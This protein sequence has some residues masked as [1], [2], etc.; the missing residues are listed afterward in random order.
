MA[1]NE[2]MGIATTAKI[3]KHPVHPMLIAFPIAFFLATLAG[4]LT[5]WLS[6]DRLA[7]DIAFWSLGAGILTAALAAVAGLIDFAGNARIRALSHAWQHMIGNVIVV[8]LAVISFWIRYRYGAADAILPWGLTLSLVI[9]LLLGFTGW[10][11]GDL[12][13]LHRVGMHPEAPRQ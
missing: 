12:V 5:F 7:A 3:G 6:E 13:Y 1:Q 4:D 11:G 10:R 2:L 9:A 8:V